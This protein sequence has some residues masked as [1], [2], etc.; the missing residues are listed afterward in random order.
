MNPLPFVPP[1]L[2]FELVTRKVHWVWGHLLRQNS[3]GRKLNPMKKWK[4]STGRK[5]QVSS[6]IRNGPRTGSLFMSPSLFLILA[7]FLS[8]KVKTHPKVFHLSRTVW[9]THC[10]FSGWSQVCSL[11]TQPAYPFSK[12]FALVLYLQSSRWG[13]CS[14]LGLPLGNY[15]SILVGYHRLSMP[16]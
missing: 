7:M 5:S 13:T 14:H 6:S 3:L 10:M 15:L 4:P 1:L 8:I 11:Y 2:F 16:L 9:S 12:S